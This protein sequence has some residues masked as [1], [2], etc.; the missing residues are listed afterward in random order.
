[1]VLAMMNRETTTSMATSTA[2]T[3][4]AMLRTMT[5]PWA[6][7][8]GRLGMGHS[9]DSLHLQTRWPPSARCP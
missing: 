5:K 2:A 7:S 9:P 8:N 6:I 4:V 1:M 3:P